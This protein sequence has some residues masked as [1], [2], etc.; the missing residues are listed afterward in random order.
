MK[1]L[2]KIY[3]MGFSFLP[4][5][6][7]FFSKN[8]WVSTQ[9]MVCFVNKLEPALAEKVFPNYSCIENGLILLICW[10]VILTTCQIWL[11]FQ[12]M[13]SKKELSLARAISLSPSISVIEWLSLHAVAYAYHCF[14]GMNVR[15][16]SPPQSICLSLFD[17]I[18]LWKKKKKLL[19][20]YI[21]L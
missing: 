10:R 13:L 11:L 14:Y 18:G 8:F 17:T 3:W 21:Y 15:Q 16:N 5:F 20:W 9:H 6:L 2:T 19:Y 4:F 12:F 7:L 1:I